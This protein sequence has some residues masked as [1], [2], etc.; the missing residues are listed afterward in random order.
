MARLQARL[1]GVE[2]DDP[3]VLVVHRAQHDR[4]AVAGGVPA[5]RTATA[6]AAIQA[7]AAVALQRVLACRATQIGQ[8]VAGDAGQAIQREFAHHGRV[9]VHQPVALRQRLVAAHAGAHGFGLLVAGFGHVHGHFAALPGVG[10][11]G[12]GGD[13]QPA[14]VGRKRA[15]LDGHV[16]AEIDGSG[17][18]GRVGGAPGVVLFAR[19]VAALAVLAQ[20]ADQ[21]QLALTQVVGLGRL[22]RILLGAHIGGLHHAAAV[23]ALPLLAAAPA[24]RTV[25]APLQAGGGFVAAGQLGQ[26]AAAQV[27]HEH[28]AVAHQ[29]HARA[30]G[31]VQEV[32][33]VHVR[34][35]RAVQPRGHAA[36]V[37][38]LAETV[39]D[40]RAFALAGVFHRL[41]IPA[42]PGLFHA[43]A[44]PVRVGHHLFQGQRLRG[45]RGQPRGGGKQQAGGKDA[46]HGDLAGGQR[47]QVS[48]ARTG[49]EPPQVMARGSPVARFQA[50][51]RSALRTPRCKATSTRA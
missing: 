10:G 1:R 6:A 50:Q 29:R 13:H 44:D 26:R 24:Q 46:A 32:A 30:G 12:S 11:L 45:L 5:D 25:A 28:V 17:C 14:A 19:G 48:S 27:A 21:A 35:R 40:G 4:G 31:V 16:R 8:R 3:A 42:P 39:A 20:A 43:I 15:V 34:A 2:A 51:S 9:H 41:R 7:H 38:A 22:G 18:A 23:P 36:P 37:D 49:G 33:A 47:Q